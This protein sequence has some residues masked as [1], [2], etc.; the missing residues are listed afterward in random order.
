MDLITL[1]SLGIISLAA[2]GYSIPL[3]KVYRLS[4]KL[5]GCSTLSSLKDLSST[6]IN[7]FDTPEGN[8]KTTLKA[9]EFFNE[10]Q[11]AL[12]VNTNMHAIMSAPSIL[13]GLGVLGTFVGLAVAVTNFDSSNAEMISTSIKNLLSGMGTAF[14]TSL[15]GMSL[16]IVYIFFQKATFNQLGKSLLKLCSALDSSFY[17]SDLDVIRMENSEQTRLQN[18]G[19][20]RQMRENSIDQSQSLK[21]WSDGMIAAIQQSFS[22]SMQE[23]QDKTSK[24][25]TEFNRQF[26]NYLQSKFDEQASAI[27]KES[28]Q[29]KDFLNELRQNHVE[30]LQSLKLWSEE[31]TTAFQ[32]SFSKSILEQQ[33][34]ASKEAAESNRQLVSCLQSK[35]DEQASAIS[36][37]SN[38]NK[39]FLNELQQNHVEQLQS[40]KLWSEELTTAFQQ[41][42]SKSILEQQDKAS[43]EAAESNRQIVSCLQS[44]LDEQASAISNESAQNKEL[45]NELQQNNIKQLES[46]KQWSENMIEASL[47]A[48]KTSMQELQ[49]GVANDSQEFN[50]QFILSLQNKFEE[51]AERREAMHSELMKAI[52][53]YDE[54]DNESTIGNALQCI[55][56]EAEKQSQALESFTTDLSNELNSSLG[57]TMNESIVPLIHDLE[58]THLALG[59][60][61]DNMTNQIQAPATEMVNRVTSDLK[62]AMIQMTSEFKEQISTDTVNKMMALAENLSKTSEILNLVPQ[63]M[64][65]MSDTIKKNFNSVQG[66]FGQI[67][68]S[69]QD[70]QSQMIES[71]RNVSDELAL[72]MQIKFEEMMGSVKET[73]T[74]LN[75]QHMGVMDTQSRSTREIERLLSSFADSVQRMHISNQETSNTLVKLRSVCDGMEDAANKMNEISSRMTDAS[76]GLLNQQKEVMQKYADVQNS[77]QETLSQII[78]ALNSSKVLVE[79]YSQGFGIIQG[80]LEGIF[81]QITEGLQQYSAT[82]RT[83]TGEALAKYSDVLTETTKGLQNMAQSLI[84]SAE[85]IAESIDL[86]KI[87]LR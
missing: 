47:D 78:D 25:S 45:L 15:L 87:K 81:A 42:F 37:E 30:Q 65:A 77:N 62:S 59:N 29:N 8:N 44:K 56:E 73:M 55:Y 49:N 41:S 72:G 27:S 7:E 4:Q 86:F 67:Q 33:D 71:S 38:Q 22:K 57:R 14:Y 39:D 20:L 70:Q 17:I 48:F 31:L 28:N 75:E 9:E 2:A 52:T 83:S 79:D 69:I 40:L 21:R 32:Q 13:S 43:K 34:K 24:E 1:T 5:K 36:K 68:N 35:L 50:R 58:R 66:L 64:E 10:E 16:S 82:L 6:R 63:T 23:L 74:K 60:K 80:G 18:E 26:I 12:V 51:Q 76:N 53:F 61:L 19:L 11:M 84:D 54:E 85:E 46:L 3:Y